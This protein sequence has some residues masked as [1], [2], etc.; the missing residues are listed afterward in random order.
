MLNDISRIGSGMPQ[1]TVGNK[2]ASNR[3]P[4]LT[5]MVR[6][7]RAA[8]TYWRVLGPKVTAYTRTIAPNILDCRMGAGNDCIGR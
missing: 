4:E 1:P 6:D 5:R 8:L 7:H 2:A 3:N